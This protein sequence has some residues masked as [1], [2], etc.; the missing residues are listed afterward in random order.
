MTKLREPSSVVDMA[1]MCRYGQGL[2]STMTEASDDDIKIAKEILR[3]FETCDFYEIEDSLAKATDQVFEHSFGGRDVSDLMIDKDCR[4]PSKV[5]AFWSPGSTVRFHDREELFPFM[6][7]AVEDE[8]GSG[9]VIVFLVSPYFGALHQ[10]HYIPGTE[11]TVFLSGEVQFSTEENQQI[12]AMHTLTVAA[13]CSLLNQPGFIKKEPAGSR[14]ERRAAKRSGAYANDAWH[15]I[16]W[17]IG[18]EVK[19]KLSRDEPVRCMP[20][21]YTRGHWRRAEEGWKNTTLRKDGFWYQWIEGFWSGHPAFG[22]KKSYHA[23]KMG[24]AA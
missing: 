11:G 16:T 13:I 20:L 22:I 7:L 21:H 24:D 19:A 18:E 2:V 1:E 23:P 10:G 5:C 9:A 17:N 8:D 3:V 6:Y 12:H 4:L 15:K 14:Q